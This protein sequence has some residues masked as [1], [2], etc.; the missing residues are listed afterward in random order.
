MTEGYSTASAEA[1]A[2]GFGA[3]MGLP[4]IKRNSD[5]LRVTSRVGEGTRVSFTVYLQPGGHRARRRAISLYASADRCRDCR[6]CLAA[7]PTQAMRV[8]DGRPSVLEHLCIDCAAVHR[9]PAA[10]GALTMRDEL[11]R[12][13]T[14][15]P[16]GRRCSGRAAGAA[17]RVRSRLPARRSVF[18]A[19]G[20]LGFAEVVTAAPFEEAL[21][22]ATLVLAAAATR[23]S[24]R[25]SAAGDGGRRR[26][27]RPGAAPALPDASG[28]VIVPVCPAV[29]N[30]VELQVPVA[31]RLAGS[32]RLSLG[33][34]RAGHHGRPPGLRGLVPQPALRACS[35]ASR[36]RG[37]SGGETA[38][39]ECLSARRHPPG[40]SCANCRAREP[41]NGTGL[42]AGRLRERPMSPR[43]S[44]AGRPGE[45]EEQ[46]ANRSR[47]T[48]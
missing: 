1:R 14:G 16:R 6:A 26:T 13:T 25:R 35:T 11:S 2:L 18:A 48:C 7:C 34:G 37:R 21:R 24:R 4:N 9:A 17:G 20:R 22:E 46:A 5:R 31:G 3:G 23:R 33:G 10:P 38:A 32:A 27:W 42:G 19:L 28:P 43:T 47:P 40:R 29:V 41:G 45:P 36:C 15:G 44:E 8:R 39:V 30:L 12:W